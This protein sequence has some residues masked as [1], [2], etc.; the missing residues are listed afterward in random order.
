MQNFA[1]RVL[2]AAC[3][4]AL[5]SACGG[6]GSGDLTS[7][8]P[9][10]PTPTPTPAPPEFKPVAATIYSEPLYNPNLAVVGKGW[11][12]DH[13]PD[14]TGVL[15][16]RDADSLGI[17]YDQASKTYQV[18]VPVAGSGTIMQTEYTTM[19]SFSAP[20]GIPGFNASPSNKNPNAYCCSSL[21]ISAADQPQSRY[22]YASFADFYAPAKAGTNLDTIAYGSFAVGQPTR[23][24]EVPTTGTA[25]Y[26]GDLF[27]HL[28]GDAGATVLLG[29]AR[30]DFD[31]AS[32]LLTGNLTASIH[33]MM[34]CSDDEATYQ[35]TNTNFA[36]G[37]TTFGGQLTTPGAPEAGAFS[38]LF[39]GPGAVELMS[40]FRMPFY[41]S[42]Y[43]RWVDAG[44]AIVARRGN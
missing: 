27:G 22:S 37:G 17:A 18:T 16:L 26:S 13:V 30:F 23:P 6:G 8:P 44:G 2:L 21:S 24:G 14:T 32:A 43:R 33:C 9:P 7:A 28:A 10:V 34:G 36:R 19:Y 39:A 15:N 5:L 25:N 35:F 20:S 1:T 41:S 42:E 12:H 38:G 40:Q 4:L 3:P 31:F 11:Q 29:T